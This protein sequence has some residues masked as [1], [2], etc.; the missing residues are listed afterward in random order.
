MKPDNGFESGLEKCM[1]G[2]N[3]KLCFE[4][5]RE[6]KARTPHTGMTVEILTTVKG[7]LNKEPRNP[8][9]ECYFMNV[10]VYNIFHFNL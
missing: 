1:Q 8:M 4:A 2:T 5:R 3:F 7:C 9:N 10:A 6:N